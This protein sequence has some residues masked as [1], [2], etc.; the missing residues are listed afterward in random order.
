MAV[1]ACGQNFTFQGLPWGTS[2][3]RVE[4]K[5]GKQL[6][7]DR[8][9]NKYTRTV[10]LF[11]YFTDLEIEFDTKGMSSASYRFWANRNSSD[12]QLT[13]LYHIILGQLENKYGPYTEVIILDYKGISEWDRCIIW[14]F[15]NFHIILICGN[16]SIGQPYISYFSDTSW[17]S[18]YE[19]KV[20]ECISAR[21]R[22]PNATL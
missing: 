20:K 17:N 22:W 15:N 16:D 14:H 10:T 9:D 12:S 1:A 19:R 6:P 21:N 8:T 11:G 3:E 5:F 7:A 13:A 4:E 18:F 2:K